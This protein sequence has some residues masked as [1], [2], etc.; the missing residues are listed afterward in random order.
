MEPTFFTFEAWHIWTLV[1]VA[2]FILEIFTPGFFVACFGVGAFVAVLPAFLGLG[3]AWQLAAFAIGSMLS[4]IYLRR[5]MQRC[6][7]QQTEFAT[8][9]DALIGR[10]AHI[11]YTSAGDEDYSE[12]AIDGDIWRVHSIDGTPLQQGMLVEVIDY[13]SLTLIVRP[14][15]A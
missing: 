6:F 4:L 15:K 14:V 1:A 5:F 7:G 8:G 13:E 2:L 3:W 10:R 9:I 11:R 12:I